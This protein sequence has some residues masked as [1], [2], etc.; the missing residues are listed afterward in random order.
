MSA[1]YHHAQVTLLRLF[2]PYG[3]LDPLPAPPETNVQEAE[4]TSSTLIAQPPLTSSEKRRRESV[5]G[6]IRQARRAHRRK[7][8][9]R[10]RGSLAGSPPGAGGRLLQL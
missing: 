8:R 1:A 9:R 4:M 3:T 2:Q 10:A 5:E 7:H 6:T